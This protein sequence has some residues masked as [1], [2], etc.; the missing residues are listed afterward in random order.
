MARQYR[1]YLLDADCHIS[2]A[3]IIECDDDATALLEADRL[4][5]SSAQKSVEV[6]DRRRKVPILSRNTTAA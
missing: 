3:T 6:W 5:T 4:L 1:C 2:E